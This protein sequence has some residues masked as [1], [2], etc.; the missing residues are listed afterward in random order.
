MHKSLQ[1]VR[2]S[3]H[4]GHG[5]TPFEL[6]FGLPA[7]WGTLN[8]TKKRSQVLQ[9]WNQVNNAAADKN[10]KTRLQNAGH[11]KGPDVE[12]G[13]HI[14]VEKP[15]ANKLDNVFDGPFKIIEIFPYGNL[16]LSNG[17]RVNVNQCRLYQ[18]PESGGSVDSCVEIQSSETISKDADKEVSEFTQDDQHVN[19]DVQTKDDDMNDQLPTLAI[20]QN[21]AVNQ[22]L[23]L[24]VYDEN[25][26]SYSQFTKS[27][28]QEHHEPQRADWTK[29]HRNDIKGTSTG[30]RAQFKK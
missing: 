23:Y 16:L 13:M 21:K 17:H 11:R 1:V 4:T 28:S 5:H 25:W 9:R 19:N 2:F 3:H 15:S 12:V 6:V 7:N 27:N 26:W 14:V 29:P 10:T 30:V 24:N 20:Q 22:L 18:R 8:Q